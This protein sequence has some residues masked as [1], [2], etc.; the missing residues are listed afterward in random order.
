[1]V[2][3]Q[4]GKLIKDVS[5]GPGGMATLILGSEKTALHDVGMACFHRELEENLTRE[6]AGR[7]LDYIVLS[8]THYDHVGALPYILRRWP[9]AVVLGAAKAREVFARPGALKMIASMG[10]SAA[11]AYGRDPS[12]ITALGLRVDRVLESGDMLAL[13]DEELLCFATRGH[14]DCS[15]SYLLMP[16]GILFTSE[17]TGVIE[18]HGKLH[19]S[20]L[21]S[22]EDSLEAA[23]F[24]RLL[25]YREIIAPHFGFVADD[26]KEK[27]FDMY[28]EAAEEEREF[29]RRLIAEGKSADE[30][31]AE[32]K[33]LYWSKERALHQPYRAYETNTRITIELMMREA[34]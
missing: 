18:S 12:E 22:F 8:H 15:M 19:T 20:V 1:M 14:T 24:C 17:S 4:Y 28:I 32:H 6:L 2:K 25:P 30:I 16:A 13:G 33:K 34:D 29:Y 5:G 23:Y 11:E 10:Q 27:Y 31:L 7:P 3:E 21:K 26:I 9:Q